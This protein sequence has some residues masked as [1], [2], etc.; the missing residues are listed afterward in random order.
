MGRD[1]LDTTGTLCL[2]SSIAFLPVDSTE[3]L[4][5]PEAGLE[6]PP[7][8]V[9]SSSWIGASSFAFS[10]FETLRLNC[11]SKLLLFAFLGFSS[12]LDVYE[13]LGMLDMG[14]WL[15]SMLF[16]GKRTQ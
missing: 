5:P 8:P 12:S 2:S 4:V 15:S 11:G 3:P 1:I 9:S 14:P 16:P 7:L 10:S 6:L 13:R